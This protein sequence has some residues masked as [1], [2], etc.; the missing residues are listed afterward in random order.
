MAVNG[1]RHEEALL[2]APD[3][4][5]ILPGVGNL[6]T[7]TAA[8]DQ[9]HQQLAPEIVL[10][11]TG[12]SFKQPPPEFTTR[13]SAQGTGVEAMIST[14]ACRTYNILAAEGRKVLAALL[15]PGI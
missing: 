13:L 8:I 2:I 7:L 1:K 3:F 10:F 15:P 4:V 5:R 6:V 9:V 14:A 12:A 11:G